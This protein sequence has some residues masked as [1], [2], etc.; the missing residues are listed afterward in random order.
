MKF[1]IKKWQDKHVIKE[2]TL[3]VNHPNVKKIIDLFKQMDEIDGETITYIAK[4]VGPELVGAM[5]WA[6]TTKAIK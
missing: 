6:I 3:P 2:S 5:H 1:D 4:R